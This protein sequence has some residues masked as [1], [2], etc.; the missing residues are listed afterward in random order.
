MLP[1]LPIQSISG[2]RLSSSPGRADRQTWFLHRKR[3]RRD[4]AVRKISPPYAV[5]AFCT[6]LQRPRRL[7]GIGCENSPPSTQ[8][9]VIFIHPISR[10]RQKRGGTLYPHKKPAD[11]RPWWRVKSLICLLI[12]RSRQRAIIVGRQRAAAGE[13]ERASARSDGS[14]SRPVSLALCVFRNK[15]TCS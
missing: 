11:R 4:N 10:R 15:G 1:I 5:F 14:K 12:N 7:G 2:S 13:R 9:S 3:Q 6:P 8:C